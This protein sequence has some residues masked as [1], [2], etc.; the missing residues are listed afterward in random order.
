MAGSDK[1]LV[2]KQGSLS[3]MTS[4][5]ETAHGQLAQHVETLLSG[6]NSRTEAWSQSTTSR[7]AEMDYQRRLKSGMDQLNEHLA[8]IRSTVDQ[9]ASDA[10][11]A[12]V[13]N[14]ALV[15]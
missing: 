13:E 12:E 3:S 7:A 10:H 14:V 4:A 5:I 9:I 15:D 11:E 1:S 2:V 8:K 6:I